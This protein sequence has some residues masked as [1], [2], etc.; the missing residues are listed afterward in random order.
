[1]LVFTVASIG[2][3]TFAGITDME[4]SFCV[5]KSN[6]HMAVGAAFMFS[7]VMCVAC[8]ILVLVLG[9]KVHQHARHTF[10]HVGQIIKSVTKKYLDLIEH[11]YIMALATFG[12]STILSLW[13]FLG[14]PHYVDADDDDAMDAISTRDDHIKLKCLD[15]T[16]DAHLALR[17]AFGAAVASVGT[18]ILCVATVSCPSE[19]HTPW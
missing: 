7:T 5:Y 11:W 13:I 2:A 8:C 17:D 3:D 9:F 10:L 18:A 12:L 14:L 19:T 15:V 16:S 4:S 6:A 1:M